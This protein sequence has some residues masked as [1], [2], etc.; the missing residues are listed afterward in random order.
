MIAGV[1]PWRD[2]DAV[3]SIY[4]LVCFSLSVGVLTAITA[5]FLR[6]AGVVRTQTGRNLLSS[7]FLAYP[8]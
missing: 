2:D 7:A 6:G 4:A 5:E 8:A 1:R 3:S